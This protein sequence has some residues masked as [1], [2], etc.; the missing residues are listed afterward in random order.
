MD[1]VDSDIFGWAPTPVGCIGAW[2]EFS[3]LAEVEGDGPLEAL[4]GLG[5]DLAYEVNR[6]SDDAS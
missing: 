5:P 2:P 6:A 1:G 3:N 4:A